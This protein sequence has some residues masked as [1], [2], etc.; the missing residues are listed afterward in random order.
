ME[1]RRTA[2]DLDWG[3]MGPGWSWDPI[4]CDLD[5]VETHARWRWNANNGTCPWWRW[6]AT[7]MDVRCKFWD[8][9]GCE[10]YPGWLWGVNLQTWIEVKQGHWSRCDAYIE[11]WICVRRDRDGAELQFRWPGWSWD[12]T[13]LEVRH[14]YRDFDG[15]ETWSGW[16][17][18]MD[19]GTWMESY[20]WVITGMEVRPKFRCL[21]GGEMEMDGGE[22]DNLMLRWGE[23]VSGWRWNTHFGT[24]LGWGPGWNW[25]SNGGIWMEVGRDFDGVR[26]DYWNLDGGEMQI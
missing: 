9:D 11:T 4:Y 22:I 7:L 1:V 26:H 8:L 16:R 17:W 13:W 12:A 24:R 10:T 20:W 6:D 3:E 18:H 15:D 23:L 5:G 21:G 2:W 19:I 25:E 14:G